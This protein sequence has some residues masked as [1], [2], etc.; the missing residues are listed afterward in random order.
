MRAVSLLS[1]RAY[2][3]RDVD[4][5]NRTLMD[6]VCGNARLETYCRIRGEGE[7][8]CECATV[9]NANVLQ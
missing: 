9:V 1:A 7:H 8:R 4:F 2:L 5:G 3:E 6:M